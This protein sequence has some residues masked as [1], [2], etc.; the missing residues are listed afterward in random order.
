MQ[1]INQF[2]WDSFI[3]FWTK[4]GTRGS[5]SVW[6]R[7]ECPPPVWKG[8]L[9][10]LC[11]VGATAGK[12]VCKYIESCN[13]VPICIC[14]NQI[15]GSNHKIVA[16]WWLCGKSI[17]WDDTS[18]YFNFDLNLYW[19]SLVAP[20]LGCCVLTTVNAHSVVGVLQT[21]EVLVWPGFRLSTSTSLSSS[22]WS[23]SLT[24]CSLF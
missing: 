24:L 18:L 20:S 2:Q 8:L 9:R 10:I 16:Q 19:H 5:G 1:K 3:K 14:K 7:D 13:C 21:S 12:F 6:K 17:C 15:V 11:V 22:S 23:S 4:Q